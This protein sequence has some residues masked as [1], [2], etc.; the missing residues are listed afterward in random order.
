MQL[1]ILSGSS[2]LEEVKVGQ[3][4]RKH[5]KMET[6]NGSY[7]NASTLWRY[8]CRIW[9]QSSWSKD[10]IS[11]PIEHW[12]TDS[13]G[14]DSIL[15]RDEIVLGRFLSNT[16]E[17]SFCL[18]KSWEFLGGFFWLVS[19][20]W[21]RILHSKSIKH[22]FYHCI[23]LIELMINSACLNDGSALLLI[24]GSTWA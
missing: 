12:I 2:F 16:K 4:N 22:P 24:L 1:G 21:V 7:L 23:F 10:S 3:E 20:W 9:S 17:A 18:F 14:E 19:L 11:T 6:F 8:K 15:R 13:N 5:E